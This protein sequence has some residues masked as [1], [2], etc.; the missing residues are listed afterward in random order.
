M[1]VKYG[2]LVIPVIPVN[3]IKL[4]PPMELLNPIFFGINSHP[5]NHSGDFIV[6][7]WNACPKLIPN[8]WV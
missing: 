4:T 1:W 7:L 8:M 5:K 3:H 2:N 6:M